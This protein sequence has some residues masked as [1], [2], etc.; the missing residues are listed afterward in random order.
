MTNRTNLIIPVS[1]HFKIN[2]NFWFILITLEDK[3]GY[4]A[5]GVLQFVQVSSRPVPSAVK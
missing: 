1:L 2:N 3:V 5:H 4:F